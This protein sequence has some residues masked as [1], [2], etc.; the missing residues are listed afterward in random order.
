MRIAEIKD[1]DEIMIIIN[2]GKKALK[3]DGVDQW[4]NG[5]PDREGICENIL[6]GESFVYEENGEILSFA[7]L[8]KAYEEDYREIEKDFKN[9]GS[10]LTIHRLSVRESAKKKGVAK[11]FFDEIIGYGKNLKM[12]SIRIDTHPDNFKMQNLISKFS[13]KKV[14]ICTV[15]DKIKRSKRYVYELIL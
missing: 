10:H 14:G 8:K 9:H 7:Y 15:D 5:L 12:E 6:T 2:D 11:K 4:Q 1:L 13:F 3:N